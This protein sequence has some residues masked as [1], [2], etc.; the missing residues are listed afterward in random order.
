MK[1]C[2]LFGLFIFLIVISTVS[3]AL[4][5]ED[6]NLTYAEDEAWLYYSPEP[7]FDNPSNNHNLV[8]L[9]DA[10][11]VERAL[12]E[13]IGWS[14]AEGTE[15]YAN[16]N[17]E[18]ILEDYQLE[19]GDYFMTRHHLRGYKAS[20]MTLVQVHY[21]HF[22]WFSLKHE[23]E[24]NVEARITLEESLREEG[25][26][27]ERVYSDGF[28]IDSDGWITV[29]GLMAFLT[30]VGSSNYREELKTLFLPLAAFTGLI[31]LIRFGGLALH[32]LFTPHQV[33]FLI[34][35]ILFVGSPM[36]AYFYGRSRK[37]LLPGV[38][39]FAGFIAAIMLDYMYLG[40]EA[41]P[42]GIL[43]H[44][45]VAGLSLAGIAVHFDEKNISREGLFFIG[46]WC[47]LVIYSFFMM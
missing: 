28:S 4:T 33:M 1:Y 19:K 16:I 10:N 13:D 11:K 39:V 21:E 40:V 44:R 32:N 30:V 45:L 36:I 2:K 18:W 8:I 26:E 5:I 24:S 22:D 17:D 25:F 47:L 46:L 42:T 9:G 43:M 15:R 34:A 27:L 37:G 23:V 35:P 6:Q 7:D 3:A 38:T 14:E 31:A 29:A 41:V 20:N 12:N